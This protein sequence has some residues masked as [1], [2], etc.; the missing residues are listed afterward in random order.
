M[1]NISSSAPVELPPTL[2]QRTLIII[3]VDMTLASRLNEQIADEC[4]IA[5]Y[6]DGF[7]HLCG[8]HLLRGGGQIIKFMGDSCLA[9][10]PED[11][12]VDAVEAAQSLRR[13]YIEY[14]DGYGFKIGDLRIALHI[15]QAVVGEFGP[16]RNHDIIGRAVDTTF[17]MLQNVGITI[18]ESLYRSLPS[19]R[20]TP[21]RKRTAPTTYVMQ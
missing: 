21:W 14:R 1:T 18:S 5:L 2:S 6:F 19:D 17:R 16:F 20:R 9:V 15:G 3:A 8:E 4:K 12:A 11:A 13:A 7:Y 10:Y